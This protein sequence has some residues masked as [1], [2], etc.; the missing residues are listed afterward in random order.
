MW[1]LL[2]IRH[3]I[4]I[5]GTTNKITIVCDGIVKVG[6]DIN[7]IKP[8]VDNK[9]KKIYIALPEPK[10]LDNYIKWDTMICK[11][12]NNILNPI[13]FKQYKDMITEIEN[14]GEK[15]AIDKG[16]YKKSNENLKHIITNFLG[17]FDEY[18][19]VFMNDKIEGEN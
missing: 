1:I 2:I 3:D 19:I 16:I 6:Y 17:C 7:S 12:K 9:S 14:K 13:D 4:E 18:E 15:D 10:I 8:E 11:E 5:L